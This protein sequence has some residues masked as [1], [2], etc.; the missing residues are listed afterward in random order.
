MILPPTSPPEQLT[1]DLLL[2]SFS[3]STDTDLRRT[4]DMQISRFLTGFRADLA[5][6]DL[7]SE[8]RYGFAGYDTQANWGGLP[9]LCQRCSMLS[10]FQVAVLTFRMIL[11][12]LRTI[13]P[14]LSITVLLSRVG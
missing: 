13:L 5:V 11:P 14:A 4:L 2:I 9:L 6:G 10:R 8:I 12:D 7:G 1:I 3:E